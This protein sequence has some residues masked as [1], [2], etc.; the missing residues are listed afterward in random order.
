MMALP[1]DDMMQDP[2]WLAGL[3]A[4]ALYQHSARMLEEGC[5]RAA[6]DAVL[7]AERRMP[8]HPAVLLDR[9]K[10]H[11]KLR[12]T[13]SIRECADRLTDMLANRP[14]E[15]DRV[16][17]E[18]QTLGQYDLALA[19]FRQLQT[20]SF[21]EA[22]AVGL[23]RETAVL[24]RI[25]R[26]EEA[27]SACGRATSLLPDIP[28]VKSARALI[29]EST[30]PSAA[31]GLLKEL[32][33]PRP[34]VPSPF[35][36]SCGHRLGAAYDKLGQQS[37]AMDALAAAKQIEFRTNP[38]IASIRSQKA[39]WMKWHADLANAHTDDNKA[40][41]LASHQPSR[42]S[43]FL[44]GHPRSG[45]TL[46]EQILD[47]NPS[48]R[49][50]EE[51]DHFSDRITKPLIRQFR[52]RDQE[53]GFPGFLLR[54]SAERCMALR[55]RYMSEMEAEIADLPT[56]ATVIDKNPGLTV[57][58]TL[59]ARVL[60]KT[61]LIV[62][63]RDPRDVCLSAYFQASAR[64]NWSANWLSLEDTVDAYIF[65][66]TLWLEARERIGVPWCEVRYE[67]LLDDIPAK[68]AAVTGFLGLR[69]TES[70][71][72]PSAHARTKIIKSPTHAD[73]RKCV[74]R[75]SVGKWRRYEAYFEPFRKRLA[76]LCEAFGYDP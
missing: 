4:S 33:H 59:I 25:G 23:A 74:Y 20:L 8:G 16:G 50:V 65:S 6:L 61:R 48:I 62:A 60:P 27:A 31:I 53:S 29:A 44:I 76:P 45:T 12:E 39:A 18:L 51:S 7:E 26:H 42:P 70:Q 9:M 56:G 67:D 75:S 54:Q 37:E 57:I 24:L 30:D 21:A 69:W 34:G 49:S 58:P 73:V 72:D 71:A 64:N 63:I 19:A 15:L 2:A 47:A 22:Q 14:A 35:T 55:E 36:V 3:D 66:M 5:Y 10:L 52:S 32:A 43:A 1:T 68:S 11:A 13:E 38:A 28:E 46:L 40:W 41:S 17:E